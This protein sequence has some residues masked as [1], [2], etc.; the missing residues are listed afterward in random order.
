MYIKCTLFQI[1]SINLRAS[2]VAGMSLDSLHRILRRVLEFQ[3]DAT[4]TSDLHIMDMLWRLSSDGRKFLINKQFQT[5]E[6]KNG[7]S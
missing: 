4:K 5:L 3:R 1:E 2:E 6:I 7:Y